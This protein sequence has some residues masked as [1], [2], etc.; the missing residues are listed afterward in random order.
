[1]FKLDYRKTK[2]KKKIA[3]IV[4]SSV[5]VATKILQEFFQKQRTQSK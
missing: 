3:E 4:I 2:T 5:K 1:M